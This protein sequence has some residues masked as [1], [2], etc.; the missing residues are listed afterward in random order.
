M[1]H[2]KIPLL[3]A[4]LAIAVFADPSSSDAQHLR[5]RQPLQAGFRW[6][7]QGWSA[8]YHHR[9]PGPNTDYYNPYTA[10]NSMLISQQPGYQEPQH[11]Y[12][13]RPNSGGVPASVYAPTSGTNSGGYYGY[14]QSI[15]PTFVPSDD[16]NDPVDETGELDNNN[17]FDAGDASDPVD[18]TGELDNDFD[19]S[20]IKSDPNEP[21]SIRV[22]EETGAEDADFEE[23]S[24]DDGFGDGFDDD[25]EFDDASVNAT[26]AGYSRQSKESLEALDFRSFMVN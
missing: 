4:V 6:L 25:K 3:L 2:S 22:D 26:K 17:D 19:T 18:E 9:N 11:Q 21:G 5:S 15:R 10:H 24:S 16:A 7:G 23:S 20:G 1:R 8:G 12:G 14:G 13:N